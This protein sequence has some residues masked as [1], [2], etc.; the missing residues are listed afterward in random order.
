M[1]DDHTND[2]CFLKTIIKMGLKPL[3]TIGN[4]PI[5]KMTELQ[6]EILFWCEVYSGIKPS[7]KFACLRFSH[8]RENDKKYI[9]FVRKPDNAINEKFRFFG[10]QP[11]VRK[12]C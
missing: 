6:G 1:Y 4:Y 2:D 9:Q 5:C 3:Y 8:C 11:S 10:I 12:V 7:W